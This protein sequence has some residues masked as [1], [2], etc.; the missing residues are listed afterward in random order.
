MSSQI[1]GI[2]NILATP[3]DSGLNVDKQ[4]LRRLVEFQL[5]KGVAGLT[6]LGVLGEAAKLSTDERAL[7]AD[8]VFA[9][10]NGRVP[11][12]VGT[13]HADVDTCVQLSKQAF[14]AGAAGVMIAPPKMPGASDDDIIA[15]FSRVASAVDGSIVVQDFPPVNNITMSAGMLARLAEQIPSARTLKLEDP[16]LMEKIGAIRE[17]TDRYAIF[18][19]LGGMFLL[20]ELERGAA[21]TMTGFA[22]SEVLV[23][24]Y[25]AF[26]AGDQPT[27][28]AVFDQFLPLIRYENQPVIN[29]TI[30]KELLFRRGAIAHPAL[31]PPYVGVSADTHGEMDRVLRRVG[32]TDPKQNLTF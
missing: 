30:R 6:I 26:R 14:A 12:V 5:D 23:K 19:G 10:V 31:R 20:E 1:T 3:F 29:L 2:F 25:A 27:A 13:S 17:L 32:I 18:G 9:T 7:V 28:E 16:P 21:G 15:L 22:F 24:V 11:I 4:S 8:I